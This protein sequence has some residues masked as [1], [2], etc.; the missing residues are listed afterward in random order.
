MRILSPPL[1]VRRSHGNQDLQHSL[2]GSRHVGASVFTVRDPK[3]FVVGIALDTI[4]CLLS[5]GDIGT[6]MS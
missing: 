1:M 3:I 2:S 5:R 4:E 6:I